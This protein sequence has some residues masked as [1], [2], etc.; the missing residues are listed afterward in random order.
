MVPSGTWGTTGTGLGA[1]A[2]IIC[3]A[4]FS[5]DAVWI[6]SAEAV[7]TGAGIGAGAGT[8]ATRDLA[9]VAGSRGTSATRDRA[10][11]AGSRGTSAVRLGSK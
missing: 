3:G 11:V 7:R 5:M 9:G 8:T 10:G 6:G 4:G 1:D 2:S